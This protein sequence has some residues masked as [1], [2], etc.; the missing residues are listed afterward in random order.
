MYIQCHF[1]TYREAFQVEIETL[2]ELFNAG[3]TVWLIGIS[4]LSQN[5]LSTP[6]GESV[7][8]LMKT[9]VFFP[10]I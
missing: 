6:M 5:Q 7:V 3:K 8:T 2:Y 1:K 9:L 10:P 4:I